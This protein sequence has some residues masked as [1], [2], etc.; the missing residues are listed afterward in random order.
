MVMALPFLLGLIATALAMAGQRRAAMGA[1]FLL[2]IV[3]VAWFKYHATDSL[4]LSF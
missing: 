4:G 3:L 2:A 1:W